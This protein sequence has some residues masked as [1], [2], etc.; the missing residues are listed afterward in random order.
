MKLKS[1]SE[2]SRWP[3]LTIES[4]KKGTSLPQEETTVPARSEKDATDDGCDGL[5]W[6]L[7]ARNWA[8]PSSLREGA[9]LELQ[10][11]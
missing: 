1:F 7:K 4:L 5:E 3:Y 10:R 8:A 6:G 9:M 2:V 11:N